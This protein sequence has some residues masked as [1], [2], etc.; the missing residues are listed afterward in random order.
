MSSETL[1]LLGRIRDHFCF[2]AVPAAQLK[3]SACNWNLSGA[4]A[5]HNTAI[6][7]QQH[8][9]MPASQQLAM[10][11]SHSSWK[12]ATLP[13]VI[14]VV[15]CFPEGADSPLPLGVQVHL[16]HTDGLWRPAYAVGGTLCRPSK[17][18]VCASMCV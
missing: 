13:V 5:S 16:L 12:T 2:P 9:V 4:S 11:S 18:W 10:V 7:A 6:A 3:V 17:Q 8:G 14:R 1:A 15:V